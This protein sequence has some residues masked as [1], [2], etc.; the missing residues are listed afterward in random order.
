LCEE[1]DSIGHLC[2]DLTGGRFF[3]EGIRVRMIIIGSFV[4]FIVTSIVIAIWQATI[5]QNAVARTGGCR[6]VIVSGCC[7]CR[8]VVRRF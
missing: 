3:S 2:I 8:R 4:I 6:W 7:G 1:V 5:R